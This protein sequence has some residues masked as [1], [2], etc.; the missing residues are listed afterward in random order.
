[1]EEEKMKNKKI[2]RKFKKIQKFKNIIKNY[3]R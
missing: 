2:K 1:L 3:P